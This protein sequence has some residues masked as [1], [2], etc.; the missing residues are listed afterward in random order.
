MCFFQENDCFSREGND[1]DLDEGEIRK[2]IDKSL[3]K[4]LLVCN[5]PF[6][7]TE[8]PY[9]IYF[10]ETLIRYGH[11]IPNYKLPTPKTVSTTLLKEIHNDI[12]SEKIKILADTDCVL[13]ADGWKNSVTN[14]KL[15]VFSLT[16]FRVPLVYL[17]CMDTTGER[18]FGI[19][20]AKH[21][22]SAIKVAEDV[23]KAR[24]KS[25]ITD[26][27]SKI[28]CAAGAGNAETIGKEL[29]TATCT[30]HSANRLLINMVDEEFE[31]IVRSVIGKF[32]DPAIEKQLVE[33]GGTKL[34]NYPDTRFCYFRDSCESI[35]TNISI[36]RDI[37]NDDNFNIQQE[38]C[39]IINGNEFKCEIEEVLSNFEP[40]CKLINQCQDSKC[41]IAD[42]TE[43]WLKLELPTDKYDHLINE[44]RQLGN[45]IHPVGCAANYLHPKYKGQL[46]D[47]TQ[48]ESAQEFFRHFMDAQT[49]NELEDFEDDRDSYEYLAENCSDPLAF[50]SLCKPYFPKLAEFAR[51]ILV[52]PA[53]TARLESLFSEWTYVHNKY[54]NRLGELTSSQL[55]DTYHYLNMTGPK[56]RRKSYRK[57][58]RFDDD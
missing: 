15:L 34:K 39:D 53:S 3:A 23:Y 12:E 17:T 51:S 29:M 7:T 16:N 8:K 48:L 45:A 4:F 54:R 18:E 43:M 30:S 57:R 38:I 50:W 41:N 52:I 27:D 47:E 49:L 42:A 58:V 11:R 19:N 40:V 14:R 24:V 46:L 1:D 6:V 21:F 33:R 37:S 35:Y 44:R 56:H 10:V 31:T 55:I 5:V 32:R 20:L 36:M 28:K 22:N 2:I 26:K 9:F 13:Q 25:T